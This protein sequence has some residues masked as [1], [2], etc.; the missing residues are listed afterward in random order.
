[1]SFALRDVLSN[2]LPANLIEVIIFNY[3]NIS[4]L[5]VE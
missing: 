3:N 1:M 4:T 5:P 2:V